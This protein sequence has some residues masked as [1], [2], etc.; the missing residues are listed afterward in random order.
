MNTGVHVSLSILVSSVC[1]PS[2]G[3]TGSY[4]SSISRIRI[5]ILAHRSIF[6]SLWQ[7]HTVLMT[8]ALQ[9]S[10]KSGR[11]IPPVP[12]FFLKNA[13]AILV[14]LFISIQTVKL[15][16]LVF[17]KYCWQLDRGFIESIDCFA[18]YT[19]FHY[20][21]SSDSWTWYISASISVL[22]DFFHQ[23]FIVFYIQVFRFFRQ[24]Y[25]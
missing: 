10:L 24:I 15:F 21:D 20:I 6:L 4:A 16:V 25:S 9:Q 13:L 11:L 23:C 5:Y 8:V 1:M 2:S 17:E 18:Q 22:F 3:I 19:H 12:F 14:F 7:Y